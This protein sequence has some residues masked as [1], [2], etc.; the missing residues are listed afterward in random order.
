MLAE[1]FY[2]RGQLCSSRTLLRQV[3]RQICFA[4]LHNLRLALNI[5]DCS[6]KN[7][8]PSTSKQVYF[9]NWACALMHDSS[10]HPRLCYFCRHTQ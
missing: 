4:F 8:F 5:T 1:G 3:C 2:H 6:S 7:V 9:C 10:T